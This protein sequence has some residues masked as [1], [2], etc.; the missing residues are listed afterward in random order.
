MTVKEIANL[1]EGEIISYEDNERY[2]S[3]VYICDLLSFAM[4]KVKE[5]YIWLTIQG[6]V[7]VVGV[8][9]LTD[10]LCVVICE[11]VIPNEET[12]E[13]AKRENITIIT[14]KKSTYEAATILYG[15]M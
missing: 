15:K 3:D 4:A 5:D 9:S 13:T 6:N 1:L 10:A 14:C 2:A 7:N 11:G 12:I 8:A